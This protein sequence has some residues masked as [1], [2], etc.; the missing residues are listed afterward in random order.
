MASLNE[1]GAFL[2]KNGIKRDKNGKWHL[3]GRF[4]ELFYHPYLEVCFF[5]FM[6]ID[7]VSACKFDSCVCHFLSWVILHVSF[8]S[9]KTSIVYWLTAMVRPVQVCS[10]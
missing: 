7:N 4:A 3:F 8:T 5:F 6:F 1:N 2:R 9:E 10:G